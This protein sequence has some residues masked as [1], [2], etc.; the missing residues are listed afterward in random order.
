[1]S[2]QGGVAAWE[3]GGL[4]GFSLGVGALVVAASIAGALPEA[5]VGRLALNPWRPGRIGARSAARRR[6]LLAG[7]PYAAGTL[8][9]YAAGIARRDTDI[10]P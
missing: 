1:M 5:D 2:G 8:A 6:T 4:V 7:F 10:V 9:P 3:R